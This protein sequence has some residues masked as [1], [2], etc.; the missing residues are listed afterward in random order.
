MAI[1]PNGASIVEMRNDA[2]AA[3]MQ[4]SAP[5]MSVRVAPIWLYASAHRQNRTAPPMAVTMLTGMM[6]TSPT[7]P[8]M[9]ARP[10]AAVPAAVRATAAHENVLCLLSRPM[11]GANKTNARNV[12]MSPMRMPV[13]NAVR[14]AGSNTSPGKMDATCVQHSQAMSRPIPK[15]RSGYMSADRG[16]SSPA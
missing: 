13:S 1:T 3:A 15:K 6:T 12:P 7:P 2:A 8:G 11:R 4:D 10:T 16:S 14:S 9:S 5:Y